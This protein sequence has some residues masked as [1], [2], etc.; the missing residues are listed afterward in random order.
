MVW[1]LKAHSFCALSDTPPPQ[2]L[3]DQ[4]VCSRWKCVIRKSFIRR[5]RV[6][7]SSTQTHRASEYQILHQFLQTPL[8]SPVLGA[9]SGL[10]VKLDGDYWSARR[11]P[12]VS[13]EDWRPHQRC[14]L[15]RSS[16]GGE[17]RPVVSLLSG[18]LCLREWVSVCV[19]GG[20]QVFTSTMFK[21]S[22]WNEEGDNNK[23]TW[24][25]EESCLQTEEL[26]STYTAGLI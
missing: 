11:T 15:A 8:S 4:E 14:F 16:S 21:Q 22:G 20:C 26:R 25:E 10:V 13:A 18:L 23:H 24:E 5:R 9:L 2:L 12:V 7:I 3:L 6:L 17:D 1:E 19:W